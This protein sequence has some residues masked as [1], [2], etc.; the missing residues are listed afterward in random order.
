MVTQ[1]EIFQHVWPDRVVEA[2]ALQ[3][4]MSALREAL[5]VRRDII[6]TVAGK[7]PWHPILGHKQKWIA[8]T[9]I[10]AVDEAA[11]LMPRS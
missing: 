11:G 4:Q 3:A 9:L 2:N 6:Q 8:E 1:D 5:G 10:S 7:R